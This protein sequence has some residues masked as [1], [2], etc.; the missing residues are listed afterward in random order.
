MRALLLKGNK[1]LI[2]KLNI[3]SIDKPAAAV[4]F[5]AYIKI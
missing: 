5:F 1:L 3:K 4:H 2:K